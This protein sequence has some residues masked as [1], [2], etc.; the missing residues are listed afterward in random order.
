M[1]VVVTAGPTREHV[2]AVDAVD[3]LGESRA[4]PP[5]RLGLVT[6]IAVIEDGVLLA[7]ANARWIRRYDREGKFL[8]NIGEQHRK[9]GFHI[10]N[11]VV[12]FDVDDRGIV[13]VANPGMHRVERYSADGTLLGRFGRFDG[14][15]LPATGGHEGHIA[16]GESSGRRIMGQ[17]GDATLEHLLGIVFIL[18]P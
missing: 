9:G 10:P 2:A 7:D 17:A 15:A 4:Q 16:S 8:N 1:K 6:A 13:H 3:V 14:R 18:L 5:D 11:G 12:D